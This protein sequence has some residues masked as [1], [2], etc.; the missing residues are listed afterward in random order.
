MLEDSTNQI[1]QNLSSLSKISYRIGVN[2][3]KMRRVLRE[4]ANIYDNEENIKLNKKKQMKKL[5]KQPSCTTRLSNIKSTF[6]I[7]NKQKKNKKISRKNT[8]L[9]ELH[10][11]NTKEYSYAGGKEN[12][13]PKLNLQN[14]YQDMV[15]RSSIPRI[16][17]SKLF[18]KKASTISK[19][20]LSKKSNLNNKSTVKNISNIIET[21]SN[22]SMLGYSNSRSKMSTKRLMSKQYHT[23]TEDDR[24]IVK[25]LEALYHLIIN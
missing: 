25:Q 6:E 21:A 2:S 7:K 19:K 11:S 9:K 16:E 17:K 4:K 15:K 8:N 3:T 22:H 20:S 18:S 10:S 13:P 1:S 5:T 24:K 12:R 23:S 14:E